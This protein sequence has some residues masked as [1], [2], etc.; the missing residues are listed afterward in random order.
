MQQQ[1]Q[2]ST[3][4]EAFGQKRGASEN[5]LASHSTH[6]DTISYFGA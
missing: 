5:V 2:A 3:Q 1:Q 6:C 4:T